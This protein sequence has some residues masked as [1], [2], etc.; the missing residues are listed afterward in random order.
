MGVSTCG[1]HGRRGPITCE[2]CDKCPKCDG[3]RMKLYRCTAK[4]AG[5]HP[6]GWCGITRLCPVCYKTKLDRFKAHC[7]SVCAPASLRAHTERTAREAAT[8]AGLAVI[9]AGVGLPNDNVFA[10]TTVGNFEVS[11]A[12]YDAA[13]D[14]LDHVIAAEHLTHPR[15]PEHPVEVYGAPGTPPVFPEGLR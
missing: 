14:T 15:G 12:V 11:K 9:K 10:W 3:F 6:D 4:M 7:A 1:M 2:A 13:L 8:A 5:G